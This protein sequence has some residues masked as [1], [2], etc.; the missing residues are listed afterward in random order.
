[1]KQYDAH[2]IQRNFIKQGLIMF[3]KLDYPN[4]WRFMGNYRPALCKA[5]MDKMSAAFAN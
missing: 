5:I 1:M 2:V 3:T 4:T